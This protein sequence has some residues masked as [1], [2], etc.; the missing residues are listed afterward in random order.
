MISGT[1]GVRYARG[2]SPDDLWTKY[3]TSSRYVDIQRWLYGEPDVIEVRQ[4]FESS[5]EARK[6]EEIVLKELGVVN[7]PIW[8]NKNDVLSIEPQFGNQNGKLGRGIL[9]SQEQKQNVS[10]GLKG[11]INGSGNKGKRRTEEQC[12]KMRKPRSEQGKTNMRGI[13]KSEEH[14]EK[15]SLSWVPERKLNHSLKVKG[16][17][18]PMAGR[19]GNKSPMFQRVTVYDCVI[20]K[21]ISIDK[22]EY[23]KDKNR[24]ISVASKRYKGYKA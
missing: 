21:T 10:K 13:L 6:F 15:L 20:S 18:N 5:E 17:S 9:R 4:T 12:L 3:F 24:Y 14:K 7:N 19:T 1:I 22:N 2:C 23:Q 16:D 11:N 8:L